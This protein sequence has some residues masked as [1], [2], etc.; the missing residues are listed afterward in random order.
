MVDYI[1]QVQ[2][3]SAL[4]S[5]PCRAIRSK[6]N[7]PGV[8]YHKGEDAI[9]MMVG[10]REFLKLAHQARPSQVFML[11]SE[12]SRLDGRPVIVRD[13]A[14]DYVAGSVLHVDLQAMKE[15]EFLSIDIPLRVTGEP[16]GVKLE[17]GILSVM[18]HE[19]TVTC[20][21]KDIPSEVVVDVTAVA[22]GQS[23]HARDLVLPAGVSLVDDPDE[24]LV[25]VVAPRGA[26]EAPKAE[27]A[28]AEPAKGAA[29]APAAKAAPAKGK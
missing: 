12:S 15:D 1:L 29:K 23:I 3:R 19:I 7:I 2:E 21:P 8:V 22:L 13:V 26:V 6:G 11:K 9:P 27:E 4:G 24:T 16:T 20:L 10:E 28:A 25:S 17:G 18:T 5:R 14:R